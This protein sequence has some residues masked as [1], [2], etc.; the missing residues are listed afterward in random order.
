MNVDVTEHKI[1][2]HADPIDGYSMSDYEFE[3]K[4][5][6]YSNRT[7]TINKSEMI[8]NKIGGVPDKDNYIAILDT[9]KVVAL[10]KGALKMR[11]I[12]HVPD[13]DFPDGTRTEVNEVSLNIVL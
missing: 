5:F 4:F 13:A 6:I 11:F 2:I 7:V 9:E 10:G 12:A 8:Q 3:C 1:N